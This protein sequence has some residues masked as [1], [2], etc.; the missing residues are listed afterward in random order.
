ML[1]AGIASRRPDERPAGAG[2]P[3]IRY[4]RA[5]FAVGSLCE[6]GGVV[7]EREAARDFARNF[8]PQHFQPDD[9]AAPASLFGRLATSGWHTCAIRRPSPDPAGQRSLTAGNE[10]YLK[11]T[12]SSICCTCAWLRPA[13]AIGRLSILKLPIASS[14]GLPLMRTDGT[15]GHSLL[16]L[17]K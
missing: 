16:P 14:A 4:F 13:W 17:A 9:A 6:F 2:R 11:P 15:A 3:R 12:R 7:V 8:D 1:A 5:D 10:S